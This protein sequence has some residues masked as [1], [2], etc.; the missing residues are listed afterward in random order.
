MRV[1]SVLHVL[2]ERE[3]ATKQGNPKRKIRRKIG[4][5]RRTLYNV[6]CFFF[7]PEEVFHF[8]FILFQIFLIQM[9][10]D[11]GHGL[12]IRPA[13]P[14]ADYFRRYLEMIAQRCKTVPKPVYAHL[15]QVV[16]F[17]YPVN[18]EKDII[19]VV[20]NDKPLLIAHVR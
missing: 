19:R 18:P 4:N 17:T 11:I 6:R 10:V 9:Q 16:G 3:R 14:F 15:W 1:S 12:H 8:Y 5:E 13:S 20:L 2:A 7:R